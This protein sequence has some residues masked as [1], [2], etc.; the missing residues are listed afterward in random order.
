MKFTVLSAILAAALSQTVLGQEGESY[1]A[2]NLYGPDINDAYPAESVC[3]SLQDDR[4]NPVPNTFLPVSNTWN[5]N[6]FI[7]IV[8]SPKPVETIQIQGSSGIQCTFY[9]EVDCEGDHITLDSGGHSFEH[10]P[11][12]VGSWKC[13]LAA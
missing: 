1:G 4:Y 11:L 2:I 9:S 13:T 3:I 5:A 12:V 10:E 7:A 6:H 8:S